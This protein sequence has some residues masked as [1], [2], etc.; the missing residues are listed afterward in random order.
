MKI[1]ICTDLEGVSGIVEW[2]KHERGTNLDMWQRQLM[3][4]EVNAAIAG[5]FEAGATRVKVAEG[6][7]AI[8]II[9]MDERATLVPAQWPAIPPLQ[10]WNDGFDALIQIGRHSM[11][12]TANGV[13][14]HSFNRGVEFIEINDIRVGE[15]GV[16]AAHAGDFGFPTVMVSGDQAACQEAQSLLGDIEIASVKTGYGCHY[17]DCLQPTI[18]RSLIKKKVSAALRRI[19]SFKPFVIPGPVRFVE[20]SKEPHS[21]EFMKEKRRNPYTEIVDENTIAYI[22]RNVVEAFTR[23]CGLE[24]DWPGNDKKC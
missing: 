8:D 1:L 12:G 9:Q 23:R 3:T 22:G 5:A 17:A 4:G 10:G 14:S 24:Y 2:D 18:A 15:I 13:L 19:E 7:A 20:R 11:A 6:H 16:S 21:P